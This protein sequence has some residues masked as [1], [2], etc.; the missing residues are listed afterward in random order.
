MLVPICLSQAFYSCINIMTKKQVGEKRAYSACT[1]ILL[2]ITK[3]VR[4][5]TQ[6]GQK[7][8]AEAEAMEGLS[9]LPFFP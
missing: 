7:A 5:G 6:A 1:S 2:F 9:L 4:T 8:E 3:E